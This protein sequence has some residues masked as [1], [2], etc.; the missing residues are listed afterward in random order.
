MRAEWP[1]ELRCQWPGGPA[2]LRRGRRGKLLVVEGPMPSEYWLG[3][4]TQRLR[5]DLR[6][7]AR[8]RTEA[9]L[10]VECTESPEAVRSDV[11]A[12]AELHHERWS[13]QSQWLVEGVE[14]RSPRPEGSSSAAATGVSGRSFAAKI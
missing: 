3:G 6:R 11:H 10:A 7:R 8:R 1:N 2:W 9:G 4:L 14:D 13:W 12:L 5:A